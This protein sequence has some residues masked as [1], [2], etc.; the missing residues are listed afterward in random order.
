MMMASLT[1]PGDKQQD[2]TDEICC[3]HKSML[4]TGSLLQAFLHHYKIMS[5]ILECSAT[6]QNTEHHT[7]THDMT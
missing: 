7:Q 6:P 1:A 4:V 3:A 5:D 2:Q